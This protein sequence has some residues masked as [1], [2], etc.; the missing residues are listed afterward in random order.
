LYRCGALRSLISTVQEYKIDILAIQEIRWVGQ[1]ILEKK[2]CTIYYSCHN[3]IHQFGTGFVVNKNMKHL[4]MDFQPINM[5][6]CKLRL[7]G[8]FYNYSIF[9]AH[10]PTEDKDANEKYTFYDRLE[11]EYK[12]A[13]SMILKLY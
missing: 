11:K 9:S 6:L 1:N 3:K 12:N 5:R 10:A 8:K 13:Q 4:V 2:Q 7:G